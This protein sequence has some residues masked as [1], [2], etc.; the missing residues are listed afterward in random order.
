MYHIGSKR[1]PSP[2]KNLQRCKRFGVFHDSRLPRENNV[3]CSASLED[4]KG[5]RPPGTEVTDESA[6]LSPGSNGTRIFQRP[7]R[8]RSLEPASLQS[9]VIVHRERSVML[10]TAGKVWDLSWL[11][12]QEIKRARR[13]KDAGHVNERH[14]LKVQTLHR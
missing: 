6:S 2:P 13:K 10:F 7:G 8:K 4:R 5:C 9:R 3:W 11:E 1:S 12:R 14:E